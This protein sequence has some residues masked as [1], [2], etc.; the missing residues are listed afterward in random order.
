DYKTSAATT[1]L[2]EHGAD[3]RNQTSVRSL[4]G[5]CSVTELCRR[6]LTNGRRSAL[7]RGEPETEYESAVQF[8]DVHDAKHLRRVLSFGAARPPAEPAEGKPLR[9]LNAYALA[10]AL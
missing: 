6:K 5:A 8:L 3:K 9:R 10:R 7:H 1:E 2:T 4:R